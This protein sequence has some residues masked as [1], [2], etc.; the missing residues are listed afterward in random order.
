MIIEVFTVLVAFYV[1]WGIGTNDET[2]SAA[3]AGRVI[4]VKH[5]MILAAISACIGAIFFGDIVSTTLREDILI[6]NMMLSHVFAI[7]L[8]MGVWFTFC[9]YKGWPVSTTT[10]VMGSIIGVSVITG[11]P[12]NWSKVIEIVVAWIT[13]PIAGL[14]ISYLSYKA[15]AKVVFPRMNNFLVREKMERKMAVIQIFVTCLSVMARASNEVSRAIFFFADKSPLFYK[16]LGAAGISLGLLTVGGRVVKNVGTK[17]VELNPS[18][19]VA[20]QFSTF[21]TISLFTAMGIPISS[22]VVFISALMGA[23]LSRRKGVNKNFFKEI[24]F[25]WIVTM[26]VTAFASISI[27]KLIGL[28]L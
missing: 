17:M 8:G 14:L 5:A 4:K 11:N 26:P 21:V 16:I 13:S 24:A 15:F 19:G 7:L 9:A 23:G 27:F 2:F 10:S 1:A 6:D 18:S 3:V 22:S 25:S 20:V 28:F 12:V